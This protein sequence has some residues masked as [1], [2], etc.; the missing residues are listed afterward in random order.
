MQS[1]SATSGKLKF[2]PKSDGSSYFYETFTCI[3]ASTNGYNAL[4]FPLKGPA[5]GSLTVEIQT[6]TSC[7]AMAYTSKFYTLSGLTGS[8]QTV[9]IPLSSFNGANLAA[10]K[11]FLWS[12]FSTGSYE[13]GQTSFVCKSGG[14]SGGAN[15]PHTVCYYASWVVRG[16][17]A[18][19]KMILFAGN[20]DF[21]SQYL[22]TV[23]D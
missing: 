10:I 7:S 21:K 8:T 14:G 1:I 4:V 5:G 19:E 22:Q 2:T 3:A 17:P 12:G 13:L 23:A 20:I 18:D 6:S 9:T 16:L 11:A 15:P